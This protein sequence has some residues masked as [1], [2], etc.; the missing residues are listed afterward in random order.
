VRQLG[1]V[2]A[3]ALSTESIGH[4]AETAYTQSNESPLDTPR[5]VHPTLTRR[6]GG[7]GA[8]VIRV[9]TVK[10]FFL[11]SPTNAELASPHRLESA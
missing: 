8:P 6:A 3:A 11:H 2:G 5:S 1:A 7:G 10:Q 4:G 9:Q